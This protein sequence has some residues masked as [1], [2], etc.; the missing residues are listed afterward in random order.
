MFI[1]PPIPKQ[2]TADAPAI[3]QI[4]PI[5]DQLIDVIPLRIS[6][7]KGTQTNT[8]RDICAILK[9]GLLGLFKSDIEND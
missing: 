9:N 7:A 8:T 3:A 1:T 2:I 5:A 6:A 4:V